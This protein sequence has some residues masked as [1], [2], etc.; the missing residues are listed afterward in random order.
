[1]HAR[2]VM[3]LV[4]LFPFTLLAGSDSA[5]SGAS[6][7]AP[8][9]SAATAVT[10]GTQHFQWKKALIES[11]FATAIAHTVRATTEDDTKSELGGPYFRNYFHSLENFHGFDDG[12]ALYTTWVLHPMEGS[13]AGFIEQQ[14]DPAYR[15]VEFGM[16]QRYWVSRMR[17]LA[18]S[19]AY[20]VQWT[21]GPL[22]EGSI[23]NV[24]HYDSPGLNDIVVTPTLGIAWMVGEDALDR[25][26]VRRLESRFQNPYILLF[27]RS[28]LNPTRAYA[29]ILRFKVPWYRDDRGGLFHR[30]DT[31]A[32]LEPGDVSPSLSAGP[33]FDATAW[34]KSVAFELEAGPVYQ[35]FLGART[36]NCVG[37]EGRSAIRL[38][39]HTSFIMNIGGCELMG[40]SAHN[41]SGDTLW[42]LVG[43]RY[44]HQVGSDRRL[45]SYV[46]GL[47]GGMKITHDYV[48]EQA[49]AELTA[50]AAKKNEPPPF[51][52]EYNIEYDTNALSVKMGLGLT[53][54]LNPAA[55]V[56]LCSVDY[57]HNWNRP[58]DGIDYHNGIQVSAGMS[59][60]LGDW[61]RQK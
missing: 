15:T 1:M 23:G 22:S 31:G 47:A 18:F 43:A 3:L 25:Y 21:A 13:L 33:R 11:F 41:V 28:A 35:R 7:I 55:T 61:S 30:H 17:A 49:K 29:N 39:G 52:P 59:F 45:Q 38:S 36:A 56:R 16:S 60:R 12:D 27:A 42:Y 46:E 9:P 5:D 6:D 26:V 37:G 4:L 2:G 40:F 48:N 54:S 50:A 19:A 14:N 51:T 20:S 44:E 8:A 32:E 24:Q 58:L 10:G 53:W 34:P 57:Q